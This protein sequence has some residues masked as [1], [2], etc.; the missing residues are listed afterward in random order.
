MP[1]F[2]AGP[3]NCSDSGKGFNDFLSVISLGMVSGP[4]DDDCEAWKNKQN[5]PPEVIKQNEEKDSMTKIK[6][7]FEKY[8]IE[9]GL[10]V[11]I[12]IVIKL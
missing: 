6:V 3:N 12:L 5:N 7:F 8:K 10:I 11:I 4:S 2:D 1:I 9:I